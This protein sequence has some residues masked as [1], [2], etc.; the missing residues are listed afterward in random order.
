[1]GNAVTPHILICED[2]V[3]IRLGYEASIDDL[4]GGNAEVDMLSQPDV[5]AYLEGVA[6]EDVLHQCVLEPLIPG[7]M[8]LAGKLMN[9]G[10]MIFGITSASQDEISTG[11]FNVL[12]RKPLLSR[13]FERIVADLLNQQGIGCIPTR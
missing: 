1:M 12:A 6:E 10:T 7:A 11:P 13:E 5:R 8:E 3:I 4:T 2:D 9:K